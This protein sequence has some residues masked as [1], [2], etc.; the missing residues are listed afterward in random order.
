[1]LDTN[2]ETKNTDNA[3]F[4]VENIKISDI[5]SSRHWKEI[6]DFAKTIDLSKFDLKS[7]MEQSVYLEKYFKN[8]NQIDSASIP[9]LR[10]SLLQF[11]LSQKLER[12]NYPTFEQLSFLSA[13]I[14]KIHNI[15]YD[16][17]WEGK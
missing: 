13:V 12:N 15:V 9:E 11:V 2:N 16:K 3:T 1:M 4:F 8:H 14:L 17:M 5:P 6:F 7:I 10:A